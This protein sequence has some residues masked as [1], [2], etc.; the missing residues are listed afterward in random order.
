MQ[1]TNH[2]CGN[3]FQ[4]GS[5]QMEQHKLW[6]VLPN[7]TC[8]PENGKLDSEDG[9]LHNFGVK[10]SFVRSSLNKWPGLKFNNNLEMQSNIFNGPNRFAIKNVTFE[11]QFFTLL[12]L[13]NKAVVMQSSSQLLRNETKICFLHFFGEPWLYF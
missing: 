9:W 4:F 10:W 1:S 12:F 13:T 5:I 8:P 3:F 6:K 11:M 7:L 2:Q